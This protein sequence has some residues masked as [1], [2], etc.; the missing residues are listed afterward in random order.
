MP[1]PLLLN[2]GNQDYPL[3]GHWQM[4]RDASARLSVDEIANNPAHQAAF[5]PLA[6]HLSLG[7]SGDV[8]WLRFAVQR[9]PGAPAQWWL[10]AQPAIVQNLT[11][12]VPQPAGTFSAQQAGTYTAFAARPLTLNDPVFRSRWATSPWSCTCV[13]KAPAPSH[14]PP[15]GSRP[16]CMPSANWWTVCNQAC[17]WAC[18]HCRA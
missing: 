6:S 16:R 10:Q 4:L 11:L 13:C 9:A 1:A 7:Y 5:V 14:W 2:P 12:Y 18:W 17:I 3:A 8:I 15:S